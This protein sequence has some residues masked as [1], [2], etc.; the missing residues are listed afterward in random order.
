M[1]LAKSLGLATFSVFRNALL[2]SFLLAL[3]ASNIFLVTSSTF[4]SL[5]TAL[6]ES[7][8]INGLL[9]DSPSKK[10]KMLEA[11]NRKLRNENQRLVAEKKVRAQKLVRAKQVSRR[12]AQRTARNV[13]SDLTTMVGEATPYLGIGL[14]V[15][16]TALDAK[17]GCDTMKDVNEILAALEDEQGPEDSNQ[18]CGIKMP[19]TEELT[20]SIKDA[21]GGTLHHSKE[22]VQE[23]SRKFY[24]ALGGTLHEIFN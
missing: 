11:E 20:H 24:D 19:T 13:A 22:R 4:H 9:D 8:P 17:D 18:V 6:V 16:S 3:I 5:A 14:V 1:K 7:L 21:I 23:G 10:Q 15:A 2:V 12:I